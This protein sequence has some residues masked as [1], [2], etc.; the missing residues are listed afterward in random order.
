MALPHLGLR[1]LNLQIDIA[2]RM[3]R[4]LLDWPSARTVAEASSGSRLLLRKIWTAPILSWISS[5][6]D[7]LVFHKIGAGAKLFSVCRFHWQIRVSLLWK[8]II[9]R[10]GAVGKKGFWPSWPRMPRNGFSATPMDNCGR[11]SRMRR[12]FDSSSSGSSERQKSSGGH[13]RDEEIRL[14]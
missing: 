6:Y 3:G 14:H 4:L 2:S 10:S 8:N 13:A 7:L 1:G 12:S 9:L 11:T 5:E